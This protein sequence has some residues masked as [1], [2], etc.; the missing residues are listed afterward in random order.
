MCKRDPGKES[1]LP[2][3]E[4]PGLCLWSPSELSAPRGHVQNLPSVLGGEAGGGVLVEMGT[5]MVMQS[6]IFPPHCSQEK[7]RSE[8]LRDAFRSPRHT[9]S[10]H[11]SPPLEFWGK[12]P[13]FND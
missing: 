9:G 7:Q 1:C 12:R 4:E 10:S 11:L 13:V 6:Q 2:S 5:M 8:H 3:P